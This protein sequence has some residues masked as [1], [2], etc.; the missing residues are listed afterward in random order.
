[1]G[2]FS[3]RIACDSGIIARA[4]RA[5]EQAEKHHH[6]ATPL[7]SPH[8]AEVIANISTEARK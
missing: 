7:A 1:V 4:R 2:T 6:L 8:I 3:I 5:L